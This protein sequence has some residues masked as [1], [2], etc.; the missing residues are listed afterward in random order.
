MNIQKLMKQA[1]EMQS[2][3]QQM[4]DKLGE[5]E[6]EGAAG[7]GMVKVIVSGKG[8]ARRVTIDKALLPKNP[9]DAD[10]EDDIR[11]LE[12]LIVAA[13]NNAKTKSEDAM[14]EQLSGMTAGLGLPPGMKLPF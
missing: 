13:F 4:Q 6:F 10:S 2:K 9:D 11:T 8:E 14:N 1:Q 12:D 7:G 5:A 3:M